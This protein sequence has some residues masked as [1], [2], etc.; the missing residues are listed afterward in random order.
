MY[1]INIGPTH[2][3]TKITGGIAYSD[4]TSKWEKM[5]YY[6]KQLTLDQLRITKTKDL[7]LSEFIHSTSLIVLF[8]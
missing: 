1:S 3:E 5:N 6:L 8:M 7:I 2:S 4:I